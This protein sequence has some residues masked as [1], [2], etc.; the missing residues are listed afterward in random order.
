[1]YIYIITHNY[2]YIFIVLFCYKIISAFSPEGWVVPSGRN[3]WFCTGASVHGS[4]LP[5]VR[6]PSCCLLGGLTPESDQ[7]NGQR[8]DGPQGATLFRDWAF[9]F[10]RL[11]FGYKN[12]FSSGRFSVVEYEGLSTTGFWWKIK[13]KHKKDRNYV[14]STPWHLWFNP[15]H[16]FLFLFY[17]L[18]CLQKREMSVL[19]TSVVSMSIF[20]TENKRKGNSLPNRMGSKTFIENT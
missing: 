14:L 4:T 17:E 13:A 10:C 20:F 19:W 9:I 6:S 15:V 12:P 11:P 2:I 18:P 7:A 3:G 1:M 8:G 16:F 5:P